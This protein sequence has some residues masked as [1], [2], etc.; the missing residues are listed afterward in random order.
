VPVTLDLLLRDAERR[1]A[2]LRR[3]QAALRAALSSAP[4]QRPWREALDGPVV[5]VIA[6]I[7][8]RSPSA[9]PIA[10]ALDPVAHARAYVEGGA[11]AIS[12]L[13]DPV[14]FGG[15]LADLQEVAAVVS[16]PVLCKD[17]IVDPIQLL[18]ARAA[19][20]SA[21]LLIVRALDAPRLASLMAEARNLGL[22]ILV[23][24][25]DRQEVDAAVTAGAEVIGANARDL[26][27]FQMHPDKMENVLGS[28]PQHIIA[29]AESGIAG[30]QD[31]ERLAACGADAILVGT[32]VASARD[33]AAAVRSLSRI[34]RRG[35]SKGS[36]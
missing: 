22:G 14:H 18:A 31:V 28:I 15:T 19:G 30:T 3:D 24:V 12:V 4:P 21:V 10:P 11:A 23:E 17:F 29:V 32:M 27:T 7:K 34:P 2:G 1:A 5:R 36:A 20:A 9:G 25:H 8:R 16:V 33:P 6:E 13:T 26:D 35:R